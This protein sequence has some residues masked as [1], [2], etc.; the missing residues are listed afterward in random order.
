MFLLIRLEVKRL[1]IVVSLWPHA[2]QSFK[3][4][5]E[6][7]YFKFY[8]KLIVIACTSPCQTNDIKSRGGTLGNFWVGM[9]RWDPGTLSLY[10]S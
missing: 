4:K 7:I 5:L 2:M 6:Q 1:Q 8:W 9:C 10:Q 3:T